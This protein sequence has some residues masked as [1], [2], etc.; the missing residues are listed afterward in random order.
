MDGGV[1]HDEEPAQRNGV[2]APIDRS[3]TG[4]MPCMACGY[5]LQGM[6][7]LGVC[8]ECGTA[9]RATILAVVDPLA[10]ELRP[11]RRPRLVAASLLVWSGAALAAAVVAW[12]GVVIEVLGLAANSPFGDPRGPTFT[13][14]TAC[15]VWL[16]GLAALGLARPHESVP[17]RAT[18][19]AILGALI[20]VPV[21]A[22]VL[23]LAKVA[24]DPFAPGL[25]P[26]WQVT[27]GR[28]VLRTAMFLLAMAM[29]L[30][31]RPVARVLVARSLAMRQGRVDRQTLYAMAV[32]VALIVIGDVAGAAVLAWRPADDQ[33]LL[34]L[35]LVVMALGWILLTI[36]LVGAVVDCVR[37]ARAVRTPGVSI[38]QA[39]RHDDDPH[40]H[41]GGI[42]PD[43]GAGR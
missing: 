6:S 31:A 40:E 15:L 14:I 3:L 4:R 23:L 26:V 8:P 16:S 37:I 7:V 43:T 28:T 27:P 38:R 17:R 21:G 29:I 12:R 34:T 19:M 13:W 5:D 35:A 18:A 1:G 36:G 42:Q 9:V 25:S 41:P 2:R 30:C 11:I 22:L 20:S 39:V 32:A 10:E 24:G 33:L